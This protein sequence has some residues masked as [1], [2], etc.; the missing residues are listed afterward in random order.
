[1]GGPRST[2]LSISIVIKSHIFDTSQY[3]STA[4]V[5]SHIA[6]PWIGYHDGSHHRSSQSRNCRHRHTHLCTR[7]CRR[8]FL[9]WEGWRFRRRWL[10]PKYH[11][12]SSCVLLWSRGRGWLERY[13]CG[14]I[15]GRWIYR[16]CSLFLR[17]SKCLNSLY[18]SHFRVICRRNG[19]CRPLL[20]F[21][22]G[23]Q[24]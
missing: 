21:W 3:T 10:A 5:P 24:H 18:R 1:M 22:S 17:G 8:P 13:A 2:W 7:C 9:R 6:Q 19:W 16:A 12:C 14:R 20:V 11:P 23:R 4:A 15:F